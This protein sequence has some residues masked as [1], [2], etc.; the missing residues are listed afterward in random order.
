MSKTD[1]KPRVYIETTVPSFYHNYRPEPTMV[2]RQEWT[3]EWWGFHAFKYALVTSTFVLDELSEGEF[4]LQQHCIELA[5]GLTILPVH[6]RM[7]EVAA[8]YIQCFVMPQAP[9]LDAY[10]LAMA[11]LHECDIL[12]TWNCIHL[13][14]ARKFGHIRQVNQKLG[15]H[16]PDICTP[17]QL[18]GDADESHS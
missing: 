8:E 18:L 9:C 15:L 4:P 12:L 10:H 1:F 5:A 2:A 17:A 16:C 3:R 11:S 6:E 14:N 13:A 7:A